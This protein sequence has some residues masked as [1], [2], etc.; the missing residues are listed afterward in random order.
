VD[1]GPKNSEVTNESNS[2]FQASQ[3]HLKEKIETLAATDLDDNFSKFVG[4][5]PAENTSTLEFVKAFLS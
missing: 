2:S 1:G 4:L 5:Y 3:E